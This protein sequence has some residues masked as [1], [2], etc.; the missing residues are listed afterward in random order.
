MWDQPRAVL[1]VEEQASAPSA[2]TASPLVAKQA[3]ART[4][5]VKEWWCTL[6]AMVPRMKPG[7]IVRGVAIRVRLEEALAVLDA[8]M[9]RNPLPPATKHKDKKSIFQC[10]EM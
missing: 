5:M 1:W 3:L 10:K 6:H 8:R 9:V 2:I 4:V 7:C